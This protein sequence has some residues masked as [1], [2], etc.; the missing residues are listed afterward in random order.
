[1]EQIATDR[2]DYLY[3]RVADEISRM[4]NRGTLRPGDRVPSIR[5]LSSTNGVSIS[6]VLQAYLV[7]ENKGIIEAK[8]QSGYYVKSRRDLP[9]EPK[10]SNPPSTVTTVGVTQLVAQVFH[11]ARD[12]GVTNLGAATPSPGLLPIKRL[13]RIVGALARRYDAVGMNYD[14]P[15]GYEP[16]RRQIAK[17]SPEFGC[18]LTAGDIITTNGAME[19]VHLCIRAVAK[20]RDILAIES[21]TYFGFLQIIESL[22]MK[23]VEIATHARHG[24]VL[25]ALEQAIR[26]HK[27]KACLLSTNLSN[28][29]GSSMPDKSKKEL[30]E[31]LARREIPLIEDDIYGDLCFTP[32]RPKTAKA[33]DKKGLVLLCSSFSKTVAPGFRV[34]WTAP[35][36]FSLQIET[37]K[38]MNTMATATLPQMAIS[39]FVENGGYDRHLRKIRKRFADQMRFVTDLISEH[40]PK[41]TK[42]TRPAGGYLLW[43]ELPKRVDSLK[44]HAEALRQSISIAPGPMFSAKKN[45]Y[46][47]FIRLSCGQMETERIEDA[48]AK[49]GHIMTS[50]M[51]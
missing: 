36:R 16:L 49:L 40:F 23:A 27:I 21:P 6:T 19:A 4:V 26:R 48:L 39:E 51:R 46:A 35:G 41:G 44:L 9:A 14:F 32:P 30:V 34:G 28:P 17:R 18:S 47:N 1:M 3:D 43:V 15:P 38:L 8:P 10:L 37:L 29:L 7:L 2:V 22:G 5:K 50:S 42:V 12:P 24:I 13:N 45:R 33:Y 20:P 11:A 31:L 25:D